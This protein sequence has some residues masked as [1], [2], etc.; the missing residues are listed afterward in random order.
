M[1]E[2][3]VTLFARAKYYHCADKGGFKMKKVP[4]YLFFVFTVSVLFFFT[5][6]VTAAEK[7]AP[8]ANQAASTKTAVRTGPKA[9]PQR[10]GVL[11]HIEPVG[12]KAP[13]GWPLESWSTML[14]SK[15]VCIE[16]LVRLN[17]EG[18]PI[19][20]LATSWKVAP[21]KSSITF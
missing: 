17:P 14:E 9:Q 21:D 4:L 16:A 15:P 3:T 1:S 6:L 5:G 2:N 19:P 18:K 8:Q 13:F 10:G 12:H 20:W 11:T 7:A